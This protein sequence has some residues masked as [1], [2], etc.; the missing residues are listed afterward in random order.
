MPALR[1]ALALFLLAFPFTSHALVV[2]P[3][4][5]RASGAQ[6]HLARHKT[7][8]ARN[9]ARNGSVRL[10][11]ALGAAA[12]PPPL[13][14]SIPAA[15]ASVGD[16]VSSAYRTDGVQKVLELSV[17][18]AAGAALRSRLDAKAVTALLL[19]ALV[20]AVIATSLSGLRLSAETGG[21]LAS[22][23]VLALAQF[24]AGEGAARFVMGGDEDAG[25]AVGETRTEA[26]CLRR[27]AAIQ[28][29]TMAPA[30]SVYSF[31]RE[32]V[33]GQ[34]AGLAA[35]ADVPTKV[36]TLLLIPYYLRYRGTG[37]KTPS[38][39]L[40][41]YSGEDVPNDTERNVQE[42]PVMKRLLS[43][44][45]DPFNLAIAGG[46]ALAAMGRP[47][48]TFGFAGRAL[49][50]LAQAQTPILFVLIGLKLQFG[51]DRPRLCLRLLLARHG[52]M[53]LLTS[54]FLRVFLGGVD[55]GPARL[56]AILSSQAA[57]SIIAFGQI[58]KVA[59]EV[60]GFDTDL[61]FDIVALSFPLTIGLNTIACLA[62]DAYASALPGLGLALLLASAA[63]GKLK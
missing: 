27:T 61:A 21:V 48:S 51:G 18:S 32:F 33:G 15:V 8:I 60:D 22:G 35:L 25:G 47:A 57:C 50:S 7:S 12:P 31:T 17:I 54:A 38:G 59:T 34:F 11:T 3:H 52:F 23:V 58:C 16:L 20:P 44:L 36:Y 45:A 26:D 29:G 49:G 43:A 10:P 63:I 56:V 30:L 28:L 6:S 19:N 62:G 53:N 37:P 46:L 4:V 14:L 42:T 39:A 40:D 9:D 5:S 41:G 1:M 24:A 55:N 2:Y 13:A